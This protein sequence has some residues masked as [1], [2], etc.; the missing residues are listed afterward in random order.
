MGGHAYVAGTEPPAR[1]DRRS[2]AKYDD[3]YNEEDIGA[4]VASVSGSLY[5]R[6]TFRN[7][8][9]GPFGGAGFHCVADAVSEEAQGM[10]TLFDRRGRCEELR[11][12]QHASW[13]KSADCGGLLHI[14]MVRV[15]QAHRGHALGLQMVRDLMD[16]EL[17]G[18]GDQGWYGDG[19]QGWS[20]AMVEPTLAT[21]ERVPDRKAASDAVARYFARLGFNPAGGRRMWFLC[22]ESRQERTA[23]Q[24]AMVP[25]PAEE[26]DP[27]TLTP[28]DNELV[29][30]LARP[31]V[32]AHEV[33][34]CVAQGASL[35]RVRPLHRAAINGW[36][37]V[38]EMCINVLAID[39]NSKDV[40]GNTPLHTAANM[41]MGGEKALKVILVLKRMGADVTAVNAECKSPLQVAHASW[42]NTRQFSEALL[43][44][45][46]KKEDVCAACD[47][48]VE[49]LP[50]EER[51]LLKYG[52]MSPRMYYRLYVCA[53]VA[54]DIVRDTIDQA[55]FEPYVP[56]PG[57]ELAGLAGTVWLLNYVDLDVLKG[58]LYKS[59]AVGFN[60]AVMAVWDALKGGNVPP[61]L[62]H[63]TNALHQL[64][65]DGRC[66]GRCTEHFL[67]HGG[68][69]GNA[70]D[71]IIHRSWEESRD[72]DASF[73]E[74]ENFEE[75]HDALPEIAPL[76]NDYEI[77]RA[78][79]ARSADDLPRNNPDAFIRYEVQRDE[80]DAAAFA[81]EL[82]E[83]TDDYY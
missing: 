78:M 67:S 63:V 33:Q 41:S 6:L 1:E 61:T 30:T 21:S 83:E 57:T 76:D 73:F 56:K 4:S 18:D 15:E 77:V 58:D 31:G 19:D 23:Q 43:G 72:G 54:Q 32:T 50:P 8:E 25:M 48:L 68:R 27:P 51:A 10:S 80:A 28:A 65:R 52:W 35:E 55:G 45:K 71:A 7:V 82:E 39:V 36:V 46:L 62:A 24:A 47:T 5:D 14:F 3:D 37:Q 70:L 60:N 38:V 64:A 12:T 53:E 13:R 2:I 79:L 29:K 17:H 11:M 20:L 49:L 22:K 75:T 81:A 44:G 69:V 74:V 26:P 40:F 16:R 34:Q 59:F 42:R 9:S 66:D